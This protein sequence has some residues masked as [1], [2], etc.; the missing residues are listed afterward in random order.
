MNTYTVTV[1]T[2][3]G[4]F[5]YDAIGASSIAVHLAAIAQ[6]GACGVTV[7]PVKAT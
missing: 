4:Q 5:A 2:L 7:K 1:R 6:F 3:L